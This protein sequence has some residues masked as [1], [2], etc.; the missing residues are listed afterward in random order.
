MT[1]K[2]KKP[3]SLF[4]EASALFLA[5]TEHDWETFAVAALVAARKQ[6]V[7]VLKVKDFMKS[8]VADFILREMGY[9]Q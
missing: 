1:K 2:T 4:D 8:M 9:E 3:T 5:N 7:S 6:G